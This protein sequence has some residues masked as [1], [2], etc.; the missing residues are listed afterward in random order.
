[1]KGIIFDMD[2]TMVDN[3]M[4]HHR[5]WQRKLRE[6]GLDF[7]LDE[8]KEKV[9]GVNT[10]ILERLFGDRFSPAERIRISE[11]KEADYRAYFES[12]LTLLDGLPELL[13][14]L[15]I[16]EVP[17]AVGTAAPPENANFVLDKL[18]I[19]HYFKTVLHSGHVLHGKP[20]PEIFQK[21]AEGMGLAP[22]ECLVFEDS[23]TGAHT[24]ANAGCPTIIVTTTHQPAEFSHFN[25]IIQFISDFKEIK[26]ENLPII[27]EALNQ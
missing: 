9:H 20:H 25:H 5:I 11:E 22:K 4:I 18:N 6:F 16:A 12:K 8:V 23:V 17:M 10:E 14:E 2:G 15:H 26:L 1:M 24:A 19:R 7:T 13:E 27:Q 21:A 3:M